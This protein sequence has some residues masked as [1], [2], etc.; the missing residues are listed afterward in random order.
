[1]TYE[2]SRE[3][4]MK[5]LDRR[6]EEKI[7]VSNHCAQTSFAVLDELFQLGGGAAFKALTPFPGIAL[8][9]ETCGAVIGFSSRAKAFSVSR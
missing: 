1:M 3:A 5:E 7:A 9:G 6:L 4:I 2:S 8:R